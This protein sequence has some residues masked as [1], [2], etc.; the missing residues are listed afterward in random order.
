MVHEKCL[1]YTQDR[2][3]IV[4]SFFPV[5]SILFLFLFPCFNHCP[6]PIVNYFHV[7]KIPLA[8]LGPKIFKKF[9]KF[10]SVQYILTGSL[11]SQKNFQTRCIHAQSGPTLCNPRDCIQPDSSVCEIFQAGILESVAISYFRGPSIPR[12]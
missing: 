2:I 1:A 6:L 8:N 11:L 3:N 5:I 12:N 9:H 4:I 7:T 10:D